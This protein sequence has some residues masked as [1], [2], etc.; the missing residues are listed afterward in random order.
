MNAKDRFTV[1]EYGSQYV[2]LFNNDIITTANHFW[3][4]Y[5]LLSSRP[6]NDTFRDYYCIICS[7]E[8]YKSGPPRCIEPSGS[9]GTNDDED[10]GGKI[11]EE[12]ASI[13]EDHNL[14]TDYEEDIKEPE[15]Y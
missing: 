14:Q 13:I 4:V 10:Y 12:C 1:N 5:P 11:C 15:F 7:S 6:Y 3:D 8:L 9:Y 2:T